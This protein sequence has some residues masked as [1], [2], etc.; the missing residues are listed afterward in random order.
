MLVLLIQGEYEAYLL[1]LFVAV[2]LKK[3]CNGLH[4]WHAVAVWKWGIDE[5]VCGIC[6]MPFEA[7]CPGVAYPGDDCP[8][9]RRVSN[10]RCWWLCDNKMTMHVLWGAVWGECA[11]AFHMQC[12]MKWLQTQQNVKQDCPMCRQPWK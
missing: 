3:D 8:P 4:R 10:D 12:I 6:R 9:G 1:V 2:C 5:D 11:H 7:C